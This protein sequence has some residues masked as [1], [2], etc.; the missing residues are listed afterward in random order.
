[1][2]LYVLGAVALG[3]LGAVVGKI[4]PL[5]GELV[6]WIV[7]GLTA[8]EVA[9]LERPGISEYTDSIYIFVMI[10][11]PVGIVLV[12]ALAAITNLGMLLRRRYAGEFN[13]VP[14]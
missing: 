6:V 5:W 13:R 8:L 10:R 2:V 1:L 7:T 11:L 4:L 9:A 12:A 3:G 14:R